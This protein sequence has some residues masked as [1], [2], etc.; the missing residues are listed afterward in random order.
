MFTDPHETIII[1]LYINEYTPH[2]C[3]IQCFFKPVVCNLIALSATAKHFVYFLLPG[4]QTQDFVTRTDQNKI[5]FSPS[6]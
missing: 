1:Y 4:C 5:I 2:S 6:D 3:V